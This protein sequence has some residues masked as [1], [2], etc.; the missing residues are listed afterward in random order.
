MRIHRFALLAVCAALTATVSGAGAQEIRAIKPL[1]AGAGL[2]GAT[3]DDIEKARTFD[4][5]APA[6]GLPNAADHLVKA[7][8]YKALDCFVQG[9]RCE[10]WADDLNGQF[11]AVLPRRDTEARLRV[12]L[13]RLDATGK[14]TTVKETTGEKTKANR[15][16]FLIGV[17]ALPVG[18]Y[19]VRAAMVDDAGQAQEPAAEY[20]FAR[21]DKRNPV[22][23]FPPDG[24]PINVA[25]QNEVPNAQWPMR[26]GV[27][28]PIN[29]VM[30]SSHLA[31]F[32]DG[33]Q[34]AAQ[35]TPIATWC[36]E[37]SV[38]WVHVDFVARYRDGK[39]A[40]Y[41]LRLLPQAEP[42]V[43]SPL[44]V[45]QTDDKITVD[46]GTIRFE[47]SRKKFAGLDAAWYDPSGKG[48]YD[49]D[50]PDIQGSSGPYIVDGRLIRFDASRDKN[51]QVVVEE[52][53]P[54]RV[55]IV[56]KG[57]YVSEEGRVD[58]LC[59]FVTRIAAYAGQPM[60]RISQ[61]TIITYDTQT[62]RLADVGFGIGTIDA[63]S[64]RLGADGAVREGK[65]PATG[66]L[67]LLQDRH[68]HFRLVGA[69]EKPVEGTTSDGWFSTIGGNDGPSVSVMLRD[70]WQKFPKEVELGR[71]GMTVHFWPAHG[72]RTFA[73]NDELDI[74]NI[75]KF[76]AFHEGALLDLALPTD[77]YEAFAGPYAGETTECRPEHALNGNGQG[78]AIGN[79]F[80]LTFAPPL[81]A[82]ETAA[83]ARLFQHDPAALAAP[84]WNATSMALGA[85]AASDTRN[86]G[87]MEEAVEKGYLG[88]A[89]T[90]Q[91]GKEYGMWIYPDTHTYWDGANDRSNLHRVWHNSHYHEASTVWMMYYR[92]GSEDILRWARSHADHYMNVTTINYAEMGPNGNPK[93]KFHLPGAMYHCKGL[94]P[95]GAETYGMVRRD[96]HAGVAGHWIDPD[97][98]LWNWYLTGNERARDLYNMWAATYAENP[99]YA[100]T[101]REVCTT[102][103]YTVNYYRASFD[104]RMLPA[105]RG[106]GYSL[107]TAEPLEQQ[108]PGPLW[109][110]LW[111]NRYYD[112]MRDPEY[113][114]F[115]MKYA[116]MTSIG[117]TWTTALGALAYQV[118]GDKTYLTQH[119]DGV[120]NFPRGFY[121]NPGDLYDW[122]GKGP[123]PLGDRW[124]AYLC[125]G[126]FLHALHQAGI[127]AVKGDPGAHFTYIVGGTPS[128][129]VYALK[130]KDQPFTFTFAAQSLGGDLHRQDVTL[131]APS[132]KEVAEFKVPPKGGPSS[133]VEKREIPAD[134]ET[135]LYR[136]ELNTYE[137]TVRAPVTSLALEA[138]VMPKD[139][140]MRTSG[141]QGWL[142]PSEDVPITI[143]VGPGIGSSV[144]YPNDVILRDGDGKVLATT[145]QLGSRNPPPLVFTF[146]PQKHK[147]PWQLDIVGP[148]SI[149][150]TG[151]AKKLLWGPSDAA[152]KAVQAALPK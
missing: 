18:K 138:M 25:P 92:T 64:F 114:P 85:V 128:L 70:I 6:P 83:A 28:L 126:Q 7:G 46:T 91:R 51:A 93:F 106:M 111:I 76:W 131:T 152:L 103:A 81:P 134:G 89:G 69:T 59:Q 112:Q 1:A 35:I 133:W 121:R 101:R 122:M 12:T 19:T 74:R 97:T 88:Y 96:S 55:V 110:P 29:A 65:L 30:D 148:T 50:H 47:V 5:G 36:P 16:S 33:Q 68:D 95:W 123:G 22:V 44:K 11:L 21:V 139:M 62:G 130:S 34:I 10:Y 150:W 37:G 104:P 142:R 144:D 20:S 61:H 56:A 113:V 116:R 151:N 4:P 147:L 109:H 86:F 45:T 13:A 32:E 3:P 94:T 99:F 143:T 75:Y 57:W 54:A 124:G 127:T 90:V 84:E 66:T 9:D 98:M 39:P 107:R 53:G 58:P 42:A 135:G 17:A 48:E 38:Q 8:I 43:A 80:A 146:D 105:M 137:S 120:A 149:K 119:F 77:Y 102:M 24:V 78:L 79:E 82:E 73:Q 63:R 41:R 71:K 15:F 141:A 40:Q 140:A 136:M 100:G 132:G 72:Q 67:Y 108:N 125:W 87:P 31:L 118:S 129:S 14:P 115:I 52:N 145:S 49:D 23:A 117:D 27:P 26:L 60:L 2:P